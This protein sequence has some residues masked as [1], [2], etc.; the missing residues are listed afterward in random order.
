MILCFSTYRDSIYVFSFLQS[1]R[2]LACATTDSTCRERYD[3]LTWRV[4]PVLTLLFFY[5]QH[6]QNK[7]IR[8][9]KESLAELNNKDKDKTCCSAPP[10]RGASA[11]ST[12][13]TVATTSHP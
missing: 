13:A 3:Q 11:S 1:R 8:K 5:S 12:T 4:L 6:R 7:R 10:A 9:L 2:N